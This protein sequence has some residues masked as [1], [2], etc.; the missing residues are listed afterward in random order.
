[1]IQ[2]AKNVDCQTFS[3]WHLRLNNVTRLIKLHG[4][5]FISLHTSSNA[6]PTEC[7]EYFRVTLTYRTIRNLINSSR[8]DNHDKLS[9][10][11]AFLVY[12]NPDD[13]ARS[14]KRRMI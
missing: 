9:N 12:Q 11:P 4:A 14:L 7:T 2:G 1:M 13:G 8:A 6:Y 10:Q 3:T 5:Y